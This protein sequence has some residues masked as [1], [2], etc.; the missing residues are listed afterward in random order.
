MRL[1]KL[2]GKLMTSKE[3]TH[4]ILQEQLKIEGYHGRNLDALYDALTSQSRD[5]EIMLLHKSGLKANLGPYAEALI[6]T[7]KDAVAANEHIVFKII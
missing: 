1:V 6:S 7:F 2:N 4:D 3:K 5:L